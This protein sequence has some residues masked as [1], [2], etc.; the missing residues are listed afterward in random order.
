MVI[1]PQ[2]KNDFSEVDALCR[3]CKGERT[4]KVPTKKKFSKALGVPDEVIYKEVLCDRCNGNGKE[5]SAANRNNR[6]RGATNEYKVRDLLS[7]WW[8]ADDGTVYKWAR[9][10]QSGGSQL[11]DGFNMAGDICTTALDWPFHV[12]AKRTQGWDFGQLL[13]DP[14]RVVGELGNH[15]EQ[16][17]DEAPDGKIPMLWLMHPGPSQPAYV[18]LLSTL[19]LHTSRRASWTVLMDGLVGAFGGILY[20]KSGDPYRYWIFNAKTLAQIPTGAWSAPAWPV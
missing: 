4:L 12:E 15:V 5:V 7:A 17:V 9:T 14:A 8:T 19:S 6:K 13:T 10:P 16:V 18:M 1:C 3:K 2:C 11:A 20:V